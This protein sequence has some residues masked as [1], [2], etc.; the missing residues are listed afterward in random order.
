M[1]ETKPLATYGFSVLVVFA[2]VGVPGM[3]LWGIDGYAVAVCAITAVQLAIRTYYLKRLFAGFGM[4]RHSVRAILPCLPAAAAVLALRLVEDTR[5]PT[6]VVV[7][8]V[9]FVVVTV[10][11][12][13]AAERALLREMIGYLRRPGSAVP[14][15]GVAPL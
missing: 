12:T 13:W 15:Q 4:V 7:E 9:L 1:G 10:A 5:T 8:L 11:A 3:L 14:E 6:L 2:I